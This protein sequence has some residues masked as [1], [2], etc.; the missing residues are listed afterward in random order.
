MELFTR[1]CAWLAA[2]VRSWFTCFMRP[3]TSKC[4]SSAVA[5]EA[6]LEHPRSETCMN[7]SIRTALKSGDV[8]LAER[9][10]VED[11][12]N[13]VQSTRERIQEKLKGYGGARVVELAR[14]Y[15]DAVRDA[16][17]DADAAWLEGPTLDVD[18]D[19]FGIDVDDKTASCLRDVGVNPKVYHRRFTPEGSSASIFDVR[20]TIP[21]PTYV[22]ES[23]PSM[24]GVVSMLTEA[25]LMYQWHPVSGKGLQKELSPREPFHN[26]ASIHMAFPLFT[27]AQISE[28]RLFADHEAGVL[29]LNMFHPDPEHELW[30]YPSANTKCSRCPAEQKLSIVC[31]PGE[32]ITMYTYLFRTTFRKYS[33]PAFAF[34]WV[35]YRLV[36]EIVRRAFMEG[37]RISKGIGAHAEV[38]ERDRCGVYADLK[39]LLA[40]GIALERA[41]GG[42]RTL[43]YQDVVGARPKRIRTWVNKATSDDRNCEPAKSVGT[44]SGAVSVNLQHKSFASFLAHFVQCLC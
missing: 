33:P 8:F 42:P 44:L 25:E 31:V 14:V 30:Q 7:A 4:D 15:E 21:M 35:L 16:L 34:R 24:L 12:E 19:T 23:M 22:T 40:R 13:D 10:L 18:P 27:V 39:R 28:V 2:L 32:H 3:T 9:L 41:N 20:W 6:L 17:G 36:P 38:M 43:T 37:T 26:I 11:C 29:L 5:K 1:F